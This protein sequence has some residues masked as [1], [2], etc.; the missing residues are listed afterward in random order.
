MEQN[1]E[2]LIDCPKT[3][4]KFCY[5]TEISPGIKLWSSLSSG[6][7]TNS[8]MTEDSNFLN[9]Q[10]EK[11]P[12][13]HKSIQWKDPNTGLIW[14]PQTIN[15][16]EVGMIFAN[17]T[18]ASN[19]GWSA[20]KAIKLSKEEAK[21]FPIKGQKGKYLTHKADMNNMM[22]FEQDEFMNGLAFIGIF[23]K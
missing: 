14:L 22:N 19:W 17:G 4:G 12:E 15:I 5:E 13:L 1:K 10:L 8:L 6:F 11:L 18:D 21:K 20:V 16:P 2:T 23:N 3:L 9:E 7:W